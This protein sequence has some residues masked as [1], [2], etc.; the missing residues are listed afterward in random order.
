ML[1]QFLPKIVLSSDK[2]NKISLHFFDAAVAKDATSITSSDE[3]VSHV[4]LHILSGVYS[5]IRKASV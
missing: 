1:V 2:P 4:L 5:N 3:A